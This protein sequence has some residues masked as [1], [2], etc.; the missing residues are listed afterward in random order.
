MLH[1]IVAVNDLLGAAVA[2]ACAGW[3][4]K[5]QAG[6]SAWEGIHN[7]KATTHLCTQSTPLH[8]TRTLNHGRVVQLIGEDKEVRED[9]G[10]GAQGGFVGD[11]AG[12]EHQ[13]SLLTVQVSQL[14]EQPRTK[15]M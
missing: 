10:Q 4:G 12:R 13:R 3:E 6:R 14:K 11:V 9:L 2:N 15:N 1:V 7:N 8:C 5:G